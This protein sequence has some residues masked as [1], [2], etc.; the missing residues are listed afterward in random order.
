M[1]DAESSTTIQDI[2]EFDKYMKILKYKSAWFTD[3]IGIIINNASTD[4]KVTIIDKNE[5]PFEADIT[6]FY[7]H[8]LFQWP[9]VLLSEAGVETPGEDYI[10]SDLTLTG[11][12]DVM[13]RIPN[14][15]YYYKYETEGGTD[16]Q[17]FKW[18]PF[19]SNHRG[20]DFYPHCFAGGGTKRDHFYIGTY[21]AGLK[22]DTGSLKFNSLS[23]VQPWTGGEMKSLSF[24]SGGP[25]AFT[26]NETLTNAS[27]SA[28][29][30]VVSYNLTS[31]TW[32]SGD[33]TGV[34][35]LRQCT[36]TSGAGQL[37]GSVSGADCATANGAF[38]AIALT[39]DNALTYAGNKGA[40]W[41]I[42]DIYS[43]SWIQGLLYTMAGTRDLQTKWG[44]GVVSL[45]DGVGYA[46]ILN[47]ADDVDNNL[48][49]Y[50]FGTGDGGTGQTPVEVNNICDPWGGCWEFV[51][52]IN[53]FKN[54]GTGYI[55]RSYR[56]TNPDGTGDIAATLPEGSYIVGEGLTP[57]DSGF[58]TSTQR[59]KLGAITWIP[60]T[61]G[62]GTSSSSSKYCDY[63][64]VAAFDPSILIAFGTWASGLNA[65]I[66]CRNMASPLTN[67]YRTIGTRLKYIPQS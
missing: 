55:A 31:G 29:G 65:G 27:T 38:S 28:T 50:G 35:Y 17:I 18:A 56:L 40:G 57:L 44:I 12:L 60:S 24:T 22:Y 8:E 2:E 11:P 64:N 66:C 52:G 23:G 6:F 63:L 54:T 36:G 32:A 15:Q 51:A 61:A 62:D 3:P 4:P 46:G 58:I 16:S 49:S 33:A 34:V 26:V 13:T 30:I 25:T 9:K 45:P 42:S 47:G 67:S 48:N 37:N 10:G 41:T 1:V 39:L 53:V 43:T 7:N 14:G 20:F 59:D 19:D 21:K 5:N